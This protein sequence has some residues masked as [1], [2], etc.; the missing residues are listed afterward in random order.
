MEMSGDLVID[1]GDLDINSGNVNVTGNAIFTGNGTFNNVI[2]NSGINLPNGGSELNYY[3]SKNSISV[4]YSGALSGTTNI[5][6]TKIGTLCV[7]HIP[8]I[9][10]ASIA[11][12]DI[13][14]TGLTSA[15]RP[16][17]ELTTFE[18]VSLN[19]SIKTAGSLTI[20]S[21]TGNITLYADVTQSSFANTGNC[22]MSSAIDLCYIA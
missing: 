2:V 10:G 22:G 3:A 12:S 14:I 13:V 5:T 17:I 19:N 4:S 8:Q 9:S 18:Y 6:A 7:I 20:D 11:N 21:S 15:F 1:S 16:S